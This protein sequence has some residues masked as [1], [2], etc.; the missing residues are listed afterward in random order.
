MLENKEKKS[1]YYEAYPESFI[2]SNSDGIGDLEGLRSKL[3]I[4]SQLG[5]NYVLINQVFKENSGK[6]DYYKIKEDLGDIEDIK[7]ICE[8]GKYIRI[9]ILLDFDCKDLLASYGDDLKE[10]LI[11]LIKYW[12]ETGIKGIRIKNLD[13]L[14]EKNENDAKELI[15]AI[16]E[17]TDE[18][19]LIFIGGFD[20]P[21]LVK[22]DMVDMA[23]FSKAN[24]LV[25]EPNSYKE[26]YNFI[27]RVQK[28]SEKIPAGMDLDNF[29]SP[30]LLEKILDHDEEVRPLSEA[31]ATMLFSLK[32]IPFIYQGTEIEAK[33]EYEVDMDGINDEKIKAIYNLYLKD[34]L[35]SE[36]AFN[37]IKRE[38]NFSAKIPLRWD[39]SI[40]GRFS[41]VKNYYGTMIHYDNNYKDYL[42]HG[43]SFFFYMY[44]IIM[45]RKKESTFGLGDYEFLSIDETVYA[46]KR[47]YK[48]KAFVVLINLSDDF[49]ELDEKI[50]ELIKDGKV[51]QNN[52]PDYDPEIL[53]AYQAVIVEL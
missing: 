27:D 44:N 3:T 36:E 37:K 9:K 47:T 29:A 26:F 53:D 25:K 45:L 31:L 1:T 38:T 46:Y 13:C 21:D 39:N 41:E 28:L 18:L 16:K 40:L 30:R 10:R 24:S 52:N 15:A 11:D 12:K 33:S 34:G 19:E 17:L 5:A 32:T 2:D 22:D 43:D 48:D 7:A 50:T 20:N 42:K 8:K 23:Y 49:Y 14:F 6:V 4:I 35:D 51:I